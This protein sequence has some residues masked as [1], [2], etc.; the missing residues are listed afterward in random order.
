MLAAVER[1]GTAIEPLAEAVEALAQEDV[2][3]VQIEEEADPRRVH[4]VEHHETDVVLGQEPDPAAEAV[5][6]AAVRD[7]RAAVAIARVDPAQAV[8]GAYRVGIELGRDGGR[9]VRCDCRLSRVLRSADG[10]ADAPAATE[11]DVG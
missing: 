7:E 3:H 4:A 1:P 10:S 9:D 6:A 5:D 8:P 2:E 11:L